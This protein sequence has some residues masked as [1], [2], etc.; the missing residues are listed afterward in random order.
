LF[1]IFSHGSNLFKN[2]DTADRLI[3]MIFPISG[4]LIHPDVAVIH[5]V[6]S[7]GLSHLLF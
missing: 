4:F 1:S 5:A 6:F 2:L 3:P 7:Q